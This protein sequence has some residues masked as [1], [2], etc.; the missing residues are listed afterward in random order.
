MRIPLG[1]AEKQAAFESGLD[2]LNRGLADNATRE[3]VAKALR[4]I[5]GASA[6][7]AE[8]LADTFAQLQELYHA[9]RN[10]IW[11]FVFPQSCTAGLVVAGR[12][13][14]RRARR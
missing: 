14:R 9:G 12:A 2:E 5:E 11:T 7:D 10:G 3:D 6:A 1:F 4:R 13:A 8:A